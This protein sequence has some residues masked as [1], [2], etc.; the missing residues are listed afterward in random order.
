MDNVTIAQ[1][2]LSHLQ[3]DIHVLDHHAIKLLTR[4]VHVE[5]VMITNTGIQLTKYANQEYAIIDKR[6]LDKEH[7][8]IAQ[9]ISILLRTRRTAQLAHVTKMR[10]AKKM[11]NA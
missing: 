4:M 7:A 10:Y 1:I 9:P 8:K 11:E 5:L 2:L 6:L 3:T